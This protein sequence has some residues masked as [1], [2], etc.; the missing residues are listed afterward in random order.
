[1]K[2]IIIGLDGATFDLLKPWA[3]AGYLPNLKR[4]MAEGVSGV[5]ESSIPPTTAVAWPSF[6]TGK[7]PAKH[8]LYDFFIKKKNSYEEIPINADMR[9]GKAIWDILSENGHKVLVLNVPT[10]YPPSKV[11]G[12]LVSCFLTPSG[13]RDFIYPPFLLD[14]I[15][16]KFGKY[17]L[18]TKTPG[19]IF[20]LSE[21]V[22]GRLLKESMEILSYKIKVLDYLEE[23]YQSD[24]IMLHIW[25][26]DRIQHDFWHIID[27]NHPRYPGKEAEDYKKRIID[28]YHKIDEE[29]GKLIEKVGKE[30][31][32]FIMSDH[33]F[34][35]R[36]SKH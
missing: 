30:A 27:P 18:Y 25:E 7:N 35:P 14:E 36:L 24:F 22:I 4:M 10:T 8:G 19:A 11:N 29:I 2:V 34:W 9:D 32:I 16:G 15:E 28:Y 26:T 20:N 21:K 13:K 23:K 5:L 33:G 3:K 31:A 6:M 1:M 12:V 17:P